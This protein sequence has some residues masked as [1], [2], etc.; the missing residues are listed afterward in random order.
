MDV[1]CQKY[2]KTS[3]KKAWSNCSTKIR[4]RIPFLPVHVI[5][6]PLLSSSNQQSPHGDTPYSESKR[7]CAFSRTHLTHV[8]RTHG[9]AWCHRVLNRKKKTPYQPRVAFPPHFPA[10]TPKK[11][12][13][14]AQYF[15]LAEGNTKKGSFSRPC[16]SVDQAMNSFRL[17]RVKSP[18]TCSVANCSLFMFFK[19]IM[20][21]LA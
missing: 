15:R 19:G 1:R 14:E 10:P 21:Y 16:Y 20:L 4:R 6:K 8:K 7:C 18:V 9:H 11:H 13:E 5:K 17:V 12:R 2:I 3:A